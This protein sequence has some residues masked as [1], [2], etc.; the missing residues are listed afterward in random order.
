MKKTSLYLIVAILLLFTACNNSQVNTDTSDILDGISGENPT[1]SVSSINENSNCCI[2]PST[3]A[4]T[5]TAVSI[6]V[7]HMRDCQ[8]GDAL[9]YTLSADTGYPIIATYDKDKNLIA[10][11]LSTGRFDHQTGV[12]VFSE[13]EAYFRISGILEREPGYSVSYILVENVTDNTVSVSD[14]L[15]KYYTDYIAEKINEIS[16]LDNQISD[17]GDS[18]VFIT[19]THIPRNCMNSPAL[20]RAILKNTSADFVINGGDT[21]DDDPTKDAALQK[22]QDW[23]NLMDGISEYR[24]MGNHD[25]NGSGQDIEEARLTVDDWYST[26]VKPFAHLVKTDGKPYYCIDNEN[27]KIRY[28]CLSYRVIGEKEQQ[29]WLKERLTELSDDWTVLVI[30]HY[31]FSDS[32]G[33]MHPGGQIVIDCINEVYEDMQASLIGILAGHNHADYSTTES[34]YG[35][36]LITTTSDARTGTPG[37][38]SGTVTEQA[39]DV[40]HIDTAARKLYTTRIGA[41][42]NRQWSY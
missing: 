35:Y 40:I 3:G 42:E 24:I 32:A 22:L 1:I 30:P 23:C 34:V 18:F 7:S 36:H 21:I 6:G 25:L 8:P 17:H 19:D 33:T 27:Q 28:V 16:N 14:L 12:Y 4:L 38:V 5:E 41:G 26:M 37:K 39:F 13:K 2:D 9:E 15:P 11:V 10:T 29:A 20:I 31:L